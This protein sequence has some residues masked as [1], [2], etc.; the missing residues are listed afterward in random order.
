MRAYFKFNFIGF[1]CDRYY[2]C[3]IFLISDPSKWFCVFCN[4]RMED[5]QDI[6]THSEKLG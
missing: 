1:I 3:D 5:E 4:A 6:Q 2:Q